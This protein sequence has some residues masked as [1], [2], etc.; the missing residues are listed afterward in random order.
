MKG[1]YQK[2]KSFI[3]DKDFLYQL[4]AGA[5]VLLFGMVTSVLGNHYATSH[6]GAS[7]PDIFIWGISSKNM[8]LYYVLSAFI[9]LVSFVVLAIWKSRTAP[10]LLYSIGIFYIVRSGFIVLTNP[11]FPEGIVGMHTASPFI[12][13]YFFGGDLFFSGHAGAPFL[14]ALLLWDYNKILRTYF[15]AISVGAAIIVLVGHY[16]YSVDVAGAYFITYTIYKMAQRFFPKAYEYFK[17]GVA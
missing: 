16:H 1:M 10:F 2:I 6:M 12:K 7:I 5:L 4:F 9:F 8:V 15:L 14:V 13:E 17:Q 3:Q 11:G